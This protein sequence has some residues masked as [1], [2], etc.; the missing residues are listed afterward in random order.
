M[1]R[2]LAAGKTHLLDAAAFP[3]AQHL[4][5]YFQRQIA[6]CGMSLIETVA[7][8]Q[9]AAIGQLDDDTRQFVLLVLLVADQSTLPAGDKD[10]SRHLAHTF[11]P[12]VRGS[13][14]V[15]DV[16]TSCFGQTVAGRFA[17]VKVLK[18]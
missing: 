13:S 7:A 3:F 18:R 6:S 8:A 1:Y 4:F 17:P 10:Q 15:P 16:L 12:V 9:V 5:Q 2:R 14:A 11:L